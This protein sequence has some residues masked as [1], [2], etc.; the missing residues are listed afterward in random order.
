MKRLFTLIVLVFFSW[1]FMGQ[2]M[3][4]KTAFAQTNKETEPTLVHYWH[5]NDQEITEEGLV[6]SD[7]SAVGEG[8]ISYPGTGD[9]YMDFR[10][11]RPADPVSE[12]INNNPGLHF[13]I[14]SVGEGSDGSSGNQ[15]FDNLT[16]DGSPVVETEL[17]LIHYWHFNNAEI[18]ED[19]LVFSDF[20]AVGEGV[21]SYPGTGD[22][23]M[24]FR[25]HRPAD[26]VSNF[27]LRMGQEPDQGAI[28]RVRNPANTRE[29]I[30]AAP[31]TGYE[32]LVV[33]FAATRSGS[34]GQEQEF[35]YTAD[36][37]NTWVQVGEAYMVHEHDPEAEN[38][39]YVHKVFDLSAHEEINN[40]PGLHFRI[41]SVGEGSDG[42]SGNQRFDNLSVDGTPVET[43]LPA[44]ALSITS[45]NQGDPVY[46]NEPFSITIQ[47]ID[48]EGAPVAVDSD[49]EINL[50]LASGT[51][52]LG[53]SLTG[54]LEA[55]SFSVN[56]EGV[57]YDT[58]ESDVS[59]TASADDMEPATSETFD[60]LLKTYN[61][62]LTINIPGAGELSGEGDYEAGEEVTIVAD[63]NEG[64]EFVRWTIDGEEISADHS[65]TFAMPAQDLVIRAEFAEEITGDLMLVHYWHFN[66]LT[67]ATITDPLESDYSI[68]VLSAY[69]TYPGE[70]A[71]YMDARTHRESDPVSNFNLRL[72]QEPDQGAVLRARNPAATRELLFEIPSTGFESLVVTF[73]TTRTENGSQAQ[74][75]EYSADGG[76]TW[77]EVGDDY[78]IPFIEDEEGIYLHKIIE[79][80]GIEEVNDNPDLFFRVLFVGEGNENTSGNNRFDN[81]TVDGIPLS[82][83]VSTFEPETLPTIFV[84][85]NPAR[86]Y[87]N[88]TVTEPGTLVSIYNISGQLIFHEKVESTTITLDT[89]TFG[90]GLYFIR[91][92]SPS[93]NL[94][95][96]LRLVIP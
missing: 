77:V 6:F 27:N 4:S 32:N 26:P 56:I 9:G 88:I 81:F 8:V 40:N 74:R 65:H 60:V 64:Y 68:G 41:M 59:I 82:D 50:S 11:H 95:E 35:Y 53:G 39:G 76:D 54:I 10:S 16:V 45:I 94:P 85:P 93:K 14:M 70:G 13:R 72:G 3:V 15:R 62:S 5:F 22:G 28:L 66:N 44:T 63:A 7:F 23:Y 2:E 92:I 38:F 71:G 34:G 42:S 25:S 67:G 31:S 1:T 90:S 61:L 78:E 86:S 52:T 83:D 46:A 17:D 57:T 84:N 18:T 89:S 75:F 21:I 58:V 30:I 51:G 96:T 24:D 55:G 20:S 47:A 73:A 12:E 29:L 87:F 79:L 48:E 37:G 36:N 80:D 69:I 43:T 33:T 91:G 49:V 19:D